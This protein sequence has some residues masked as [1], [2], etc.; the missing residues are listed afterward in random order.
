MAEKI[1]GFK[2]EI[3]GQKDIIKVT[4]LMGLLNTQLI[5]VAG[6]LAEIYNASGTAER[7]LKKF[8]TTAQTTGGAI[9][10][11][12][13]TFDNGNK[14]VKKLGSEYKEVTKAVKV[15]GAEFKDLENIK[16]SDSKSIQELINRNKKLKKVLQDAPRAGTEAFEKQ[17]NS[18]LKLTKEYAKNN[19]AI[20]AFRKE[21]RTGTKQ[22]EI[23]KGSIEDMRIKVAALKK[24]YIQLSPAQRNSMIGE[25][26]RIRRSLKRTT[27]SLKKLEEAV[28]DGR[29]SVG[30]YG[31]ATRKLGGQ[32]MRAFVGRSIIMG[33]INGLRRMADGL[34]EIVEN[35][36]ETEG[37]FGKLKKAGAGLQNSLKK[38]GTAF[39]TTFGSGIAK[40]I[41]NVSFVVSKL[42][43]G[44]NSLSESGGITGAIFG[45]LKTLFTE[46]PAIFGGITAA[47]SEFGA[48][49]KKT[50]IEIGLSTEKAIIQAKRIIAPLDIDL[51]K[52]LDNVNKRLKENVIAEK[53]LSQA[54]K[55]GA[56]AVREEQ[57]A[58]K[59][60]NDE[61]AVAEE[62]R[63]K[64]IEASKEAKKKAADEEKQRI[65]DLQKAQ[66]DLQKSLEQNAKGR[67]SLILKL[68]TQLAQLE[69]DAIAD[70]NKKL[71]AQK[72]LDFEQ[73]QTE[74]QKEID[75]LIENEKQALAKRLE[76]GKFSQEQR[77]EIEA[78]TEFQ[79]EALQEKSN[80][81]KE[82]QLQ[83]H[84]EEIAAIKK[85]AAET[86][87]AAEQAAFDSEIAETE[88]E[89]EKIDAVQTAADEKSLAKAKEQEEKKAEVRKQTTA[90]IINAVNVT[91]QAIAD[92]S[93]LA[94][95]AEN[96]RFEQ[97]INN[98]KENITKLN[99]DLQ[100]ATGLQKKF[101]LQQVQQEEEALKKETENREKAR[102][103]QAE[104]QKAIAITQAIIAAALGIANAFT[105]PPPASFIAAAAT[106]VATA[107]QIATIASQKFAKGGILQG[108][109]HS[110]GGIQTAFGELEGGEAVI[111]RKST[112]MFKP[113]LSALNRAGGG[114]SFADGGIL[115]EVLTAPQGGQ[116][117][118]I[119]T[120]FQQFL[121]ASQ[122]KTNAI[123]ARID[124]LQVVQDLNNLQDLQ[125]NDSTLN[126]LT[127]L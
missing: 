58:F 110:A 43:G 42:V 77:I 66:D 117:S 105:L 98:R 41:D 16:E 27:K 38:S 19:D 22:T 76:L 67:E 52:A 13:K 44:F 83:Q 12:F 9:S 109:A 37:V 64:N 18:I 122:D 124:R 4:K 74:Q 73:E 118:G 82:T 88:A 96:E 84:E 11:S 104:T 23:S 48:R 119:N 94:F 115:G 90:A 89:L 10:K 8:G 25:G 56:Q 47:A 61:E 20:K 71:L 100:S 40:V 102:K 35:S 72:Q 31:R 126:T 81:I 2:I 14:I 68:N 123:N 6:T 33:A 97:A 80:E 59:K 63:L 103:K 127:T 112:K 30:L 69:V 87:A 3:K 120:T 92:I 99:E 70:K 107:V 24:Q 57:A 62:R 39:L 36:E 46:F 125:D 106:A 93:A 75:K 121:Q 91:I 113:I 28:G 114:K 5:L 49:F 17:K 116:I 108:P 65:K 55:D 60:R 29:R 32:L 1:V 15:A 51:I 45:G 79:I 26:A 21:L 101:L 86:Q 50:I 85:T 111:N 34:K 78:E 95:Q 7:Q 54:F 53:T